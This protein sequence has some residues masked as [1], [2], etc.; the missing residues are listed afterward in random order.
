MEGDK[1]FADQATSAILMERDT[2][3]VLF[4]KNSH[5]QLPPA[6]MTKVMTMLLIME[7]IED[8]RLTWDDKV[9]TSERAASMGGSQI[10]LEPGE[11]MTVKEMMKGI[12][13]ASG[14]DASVAMAEHLAGSENEFAAKMNEKAKSLGLENTH[15]VN[16]NG[17]PAENHYSSAYDL[18]VIGKE[19]LRH[20]AITEFTSLYEDYLRKDSDDPFWLVNTNKLVKFYPGVDGLKTGFTR[21][22]KY[23]LTASA[24]KDGMRMISV[25][26][27]APTPQERNR[28]IT[29]MFDYAYSQYQL[30]TRYQPTDV[31][32][33]IK[34]DKG[35]KSLVQIVPEKPVS[36]LMKKGESIEGAEEKI[37]LNNKVKAPV[38]EGQELGSLVIEKDGK[39][40]LTQPL[41][42]S[43]NV[44]EATLWQLMR[45]TRSVLF[46]D[47]S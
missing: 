33:E 3:T 37:T 35:A 31:L 26:M 17:L 30:H 12:A 20:E 29:E 9:R 27:G 4:E 39:T 38:F 47:A 45:R 8:G 32:G 25:V 42:A 21:E 34:I 46:G 2:G 43:E 22:A 15:F 24:N 18:A 16:S 7:A 13:I 41:V 6:S 36:V 40:I 23:C 28:Q 44:E 10:F 19:L 5:E 1:E 11:E 14:N